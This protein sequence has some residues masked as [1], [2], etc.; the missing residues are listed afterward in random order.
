MTSLFEAD[1][2]A[3]DTASLAFTVA[4][5]AA[6]GLLVFG[7]IVV[8]LS[9]VDCHRASNNGVRSTELNKRVPVFSLSSGVKTSKYILEITYA[10]EDNIFVRV[11]TLRIEWVE[12]WTETFAAILQVSISV[13]P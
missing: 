9:L 13:D 6:F 1:D 5:F 11:A 4:R 3:G 2:T 12:D 7:L 8:I 10:S